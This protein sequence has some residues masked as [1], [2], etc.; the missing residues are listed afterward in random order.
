MANRPQEG[1]H[2]FKSASVI[3]TAN[4]R[5]QCPSFHLSIDTLVGV[6]QPPSHPIARVKQKIQGCVAKTVTFQYVPT[7][8]YEFLGLVRFGGKIHYQKSYK[9]T[10]LLKTY[11]PVGTFRNV[12][13]FATHPWVHQKSKFRNDKIAIILHDM[14][15]FL[16]VLAPEGSGFP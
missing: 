10:Y 16:Y 9:R 1:F 4:S 3:C 12:T 11:L 7:G 5:P 15:Y 8:R 14:Q 13:F 6:L 2:H